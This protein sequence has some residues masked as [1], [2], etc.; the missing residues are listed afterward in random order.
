[1]KSEKM[2]LAISGDAVQ[3][4]CQVLDLLRRLKVAYGRIK[5]VR[6]FGRGPKGRLLIPSEASMGGAISAAATSSVRLYWEA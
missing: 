6:V 1:M 4:L 5:A 2:P 3:Q